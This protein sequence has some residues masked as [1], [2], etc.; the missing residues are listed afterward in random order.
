[1]YQCSELT[2]NRWTDAGKS[3]AQ[4]P[5]TSSSPRLPTPGIELMFYRLFGVYSTDWA[6][7]T[8]NY[9]SAK[10]RIITYFNIYII[11]CSCHQ[12]SN[13]QTWQVTTHHFY[14]NKP[15]VD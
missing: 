8:P 10:M 12:S 5:R 3:I 13:Q 4:G 7:P 11:Y 14:E 15:H 2:S 6:T 9:N 1:M